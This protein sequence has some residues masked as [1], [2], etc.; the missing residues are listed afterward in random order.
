MREEPMTPTSCC[1][2]VDII[3]AAMKS[4]R[5]ARPPRLLGWRAGLRESDGGQAEGDVAISSELT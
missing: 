5:G 4:L 3:N 1:A 2:P